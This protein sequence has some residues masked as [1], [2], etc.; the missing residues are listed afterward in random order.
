MRGVGRPSLVLLLA[1]QALALLALLL[2]SGPAAAAD[3]CRYD[4]LPPPSIEP[5]VNPSLAAADL[6][7]HLCGPEADESGRNYDD[8]LQPAHAVTPPGDYRSA[9]STAVRRADFV[10]G[11]IESGAPVPV[12]QSRMAAGF[13]AAGFPRT[14]TSSAG[15][16]YML[17]DGS[18]VRLMVFG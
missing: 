17:P 7:E 10:A 13:D 14:S 6:H 18:L 8:G 15:M 1:I 4:P 9:P 11:P 2:T 12:S 16:E 3:A 5:C